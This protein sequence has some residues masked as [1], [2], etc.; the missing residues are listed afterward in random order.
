MSMFCGCVLRSALSFVFLSVQISGCTTFDGLKKMRD[1]PQATE[2]INDDSNNQSPWYDKS[3]RAY[4]LASKKKQNGHENLEPVMRDALGKKIQRQEELMAISEAQWNNVL[5]THRKVAVGT[6][7]MVGIGVLVAQVIIFFPCVLVWGVAGSVLG[8][9]SLPISSHLE[10]AYIEEAERAYVKGREELAG[11]SYDSALAS[12]DYAEH[13]L[14]SLQAL[15]DVNFWRGRTFDALREPQSAVLAYST[16]L[17]YS[18]TSLPSYFKSDFPNDPT[19]EW[20]ADQAEARI[21]DMSARLAGYNP[22]PALQ[23]MQP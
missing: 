12:W 1:L 8:L 20:K 18:E 23:A 9:P 21:A 15:S 7:M 16:F 10:T 14:P 22:S 6:G 13:L 5:G 2:A 4:R 3:V 19:W 11:G 17:Y